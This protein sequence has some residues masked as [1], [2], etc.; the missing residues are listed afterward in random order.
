MTILEE[1]FNRIQ[2]TVAEYLLA[3]NFKI[4]PFGQFCILRLLFRHN[5]SNYMISLENPDC[6]ACS[7]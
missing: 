5:S 1:V 3:A 2:D 6:L 7:Q 4:R